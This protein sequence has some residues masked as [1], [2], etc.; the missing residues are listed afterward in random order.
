MKETITI[1]LGLLPLLFLVLATTIKTNSSVKP[2]S[3]ERML[4]QEYIR[5]VARRHLHR[6]QSR[7]EM[8]REEE[9]KDIISAKEFQIALAESI[10]KDKDGE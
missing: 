10:R 5:L 4:F 9:L 2:L 7:K 8:R 6:S 3:R 1:I